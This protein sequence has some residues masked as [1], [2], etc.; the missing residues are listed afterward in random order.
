MTQTVVII[1]VHVLINHYQ[2]QIDITQYCNELHTD[3]LKD[4]WQQL[5]TQLVSTILHTSCTSSVNT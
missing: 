3:Q 1:K 4:F 2:G 5:K